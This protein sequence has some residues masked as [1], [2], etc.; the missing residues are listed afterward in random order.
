M[1]KRRQRARIQRGREFWEKTVAQFWESG[2]TRGKFA[3]EHGLRP[4]TLCTWVRTLGRDKKD[5]GGLVE[6]EVGIVGSLQSAEPR[7]TAGVTRLVVGSG[8]LEFAGLPPVDY[9]AELLW[10]VSQC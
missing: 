6:L 2:L 7:E 9:V 3:H 8:C 1:A 5:M 10:K 4:S